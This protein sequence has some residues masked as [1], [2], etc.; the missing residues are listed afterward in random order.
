MNKKENFKNFKQA[1]CININGEIT[2][3]EQAKISVFDRGFLYGDSIYE[4]TYSED[5]S[6]LFF[7][8]HLERLYHSASLLGIEIHKT[9]EEITKEALKTL[10]A[11]GQDRAYIRIII[12][13]GESEIG[14]D[15]GLSFGNSLVIIVK[16]LLEY[17]QKLYQNGLKIM[18]STFKRNSKE[19]LDPNAKSGNYLNNIMAI[20]EAKAQGFDDAIMINNEGFITEGT[21]F[22]I[23]AVKNNAVHTPPAS[24]GLLRGITRAQIIELCKEEEIE[25]NFSNFTPE[26]ILSADE[27]FI[28]S[29][30]KGIM[31]VRE[32]NQKL[33]GDS[34]TDWK[35]I[36]K[37]TTAY[38]NR[39]RKE[40]ENQR[41]A[42]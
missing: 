24:A 42:Y 8:E 4:V 5:R 16:P 35:M 39:V 37:L 22:N 23:W 33:F 10:K 17:P 12:T 19:A 41:Y 29:S 25:L 28:S 13:R 6:L 40:K 20:R 31:A 32:L 27:V 15:P 3:P 18:L 1:C 34:L 7:S 38:N 21:T 2:P 9:P 36:D 30:T 14:L 26:F 11:S